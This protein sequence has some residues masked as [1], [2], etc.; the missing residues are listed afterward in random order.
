MMVRWVSKAE[1]LLLQI[2][3]YRIGKGE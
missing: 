2:G 1:R 3:Y